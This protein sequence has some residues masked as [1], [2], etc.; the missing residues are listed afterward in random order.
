[1]EREDPEAAAKCLEIADAAN[2]ILAK[3]ITP[4]A[5]QEPALADILSGAVTGEVMRAD[6]V[7]RRDVERLMTKT[8]RRR[9]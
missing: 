4:A 6:G 1:M 5:A 8:K 7:Q 2:E 3:G 9:K